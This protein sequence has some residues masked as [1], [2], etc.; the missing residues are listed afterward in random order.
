MA[1]ARKTRLSVGYNGKNISQSIKPYIESF[2]YTDVA[3]GESDAIDITLNDRSYLFMKKMPLKGDKINVSILRHNWTK[4]GDTR[5][6]N[7]G[8]FFL[9]DLS[10]S[11]P[12]RICEIGAVSSPV[13]GEFKSTSRTKT[14][15]NVT[16]REIAKTIAKR[17]KMTLHYSAPSIR[18]KE[19]QQNKQADSDF[20]LSLCQ[21][22]G[23]GLKLYNGKIV[24]FSE[25][26]Y[27]Q[28]KVKCILHRKEVVEY[29]WNTTLQGT[30]TGAKVSFTG[31]DANKTTKI[32]IG[33]SGRMYTAE[34][35]AS[36][37]AEAV[38]KAKA[39]LAEENKKRTTMTIT[40][41]PGKNIVATDTI[42]VAGFYKLSGKYYVDKV[43][44]SISPT[45]GY[46]QTLTL[47][48]VSPRVSAKITSKQV[49]TKKT[50]K[51]TK[52]STTKKKATSSQKGKTD[53]T[54][55]NS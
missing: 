7:C 47:H 39:K 23:M 33:R 32:T 6:F 25:E 34:V 10:F 31:A 1:T 35:S 28:K 51:K 13:K 12:P 43:E 46:T 9:D 21:E 24:V 22:Y 5:R 54:S 14:Y 44:H 17:A 4:S 19:V 41:M 48:K 3:S 53:G 2:R 29:S 27:E 40:V 55:K 26:T 11:E 37:S 8:K 45:S 30:Y 16:L 18:I 20:L 52:K 38:W 42:K 49:I 36:T 50:K 15:K